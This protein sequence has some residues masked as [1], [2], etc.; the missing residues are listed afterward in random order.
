MNN[1]F[2]NESIINVVN[3]KKTR[4]RINE[5]IKNG[6]LVAFYDEATGMVVTQELIDG[7]LKITVIEDA[8]YVPAPPVP[9]S[10]MEIVEAL[11]GCEFECPAGSLEFHS[12]FITLKDKAMQEQRQKD[13]GTGI[14]NKP[15]KSAAEAALE[16]IKKRAKSYIN[17]G[18]HARSL[19]S[20]INKIIDLSEKGLPQQR[21]KGDGS[22]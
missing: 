22:K 3:F 4:P 18:V 8:Y 21:Q 5:S 11:E 17:D 12:A 9:G 10:L 2:Q 20:E 6:Y 13:G 7:G 14:D 19:V 1:L 16:L 15:E